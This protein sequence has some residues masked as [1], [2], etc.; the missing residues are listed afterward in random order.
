MKP[1]RAN[2]SADQ[3][4]IALVIV[5]VVV[6]VLGVIA[7]GFAYS[8]RVE[9]R[10]ARHSNNDADLEW[11]GRSGIEMAKFVL[12]QKE[13]VSAERGVEALNQKWAGGSGTTNSILS[14]ISLENIEIGSGKMRIKIVDN[15]RRFNINTA[16]QQLIQQ[17]LILVGVDAAEFP[18]IVDSIQDWRDR[19]DNPRP[20]GA[21]TEYYMTLN[22]PY[23]AKNGWFDDISDLLFVK[24]MTPEIY[25]GSSSSNVPPSQFGGIGSGL[26]PST[27]RQSFGVGL[28]DL[29]TPISLGKLNIN[30]ASAI[31][32][33]MIPTVDQNTAAAIIQHRAGPDGIEGT[34]DDMVFR[35]GGQLAQIAGLNPQALQLILR[36]I[37]VRSHTFEI[38]VEAELFGTARVFTG[39]LRRKLNQPM[40]FDVIRFT[41]K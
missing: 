11:M 29:F 41:W 33:Q 31:A 24:G 3:A 16:D 8:M 40:D 27:S 20:A 32:L 26:L 5:M 9:M 36:Y 28:V 1:G 19:D 12:G 7:G 22:P 25:W 13:L 10:L 2:K 35:N 18:T 17:A 38:T 30:T 21:D 6:M 39:V 23:V 34:T 15:E 37:D 4:G 14:D